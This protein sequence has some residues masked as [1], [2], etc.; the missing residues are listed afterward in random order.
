MTGPTKHRALVILRD[1][2]KDPRPD[3]SVLDPELTELFAEETRF[4]RIGDT[5]FHAL[6]G[7]SEKGQISVSFSLIL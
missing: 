4:G 3:S 6:W 1:L 5:P 2:V 7:V